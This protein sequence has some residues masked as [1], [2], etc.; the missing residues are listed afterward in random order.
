VDGR[1]HRHAG[2]RLLH[3][4][5]AAATLSVIS[6]SLAAGAGTRGRL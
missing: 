1:C 5:W 6:A 4:A 2:L 3:L